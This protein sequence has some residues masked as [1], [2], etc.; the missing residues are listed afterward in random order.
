MALFSFCV[1]FEVS[2]RTAE[3]SYGSAGFDQR[4]HNR[5]FS[6]SDAKPHPQGACNKSFAKATRG[7]ST[8][9]Y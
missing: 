1:S 7:N 8:Y 3:C 2:L 6:V 9:F 5:R 4:A